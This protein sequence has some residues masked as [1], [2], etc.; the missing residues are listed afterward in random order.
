MSE[1][2]IRHP[3]DGWVSD[4]LGES[5]AKTF[6]ADQVL[7]VDG[8]DPGGSAEPAAGVDVQV[9]TTPTLYFRGV[10][11]SASEHDEWTVRGVRFEQEGPAAVWRSPSSGRIAGTVI[12]LKGRTG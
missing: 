12:R 5:N 4:S 3:F 8:V 11:V 10:E 1:K 9:R 2:A 7:R 6:A